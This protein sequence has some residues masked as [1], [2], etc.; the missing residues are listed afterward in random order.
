MTEQQQL[1]AAIEA[2]QAQRRTLGDSVVETLLTAARAKL[3]S[4]AVSPSIPA[5][6]PQSLRQVSILFLDVV[7]STSLA[8]RLDPEAISAVMDGALSRAAIVVEAHGGKVLQFAGDSILAAF[9]ADEARE[10]DAERAVRC[11][12]ALLALGKDLGAE[13]RKAHGHEGFDVRVG[14]HTGA[15]AYALMNLMPCRARPSSTGVP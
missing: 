11:G 6:S 10:D 7:G 2:L 12:L 13:V 14:V 15:A 4:L 3:A 8:Q 5:A 9:G 1:E